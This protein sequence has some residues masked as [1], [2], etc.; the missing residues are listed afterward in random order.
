MLLRFDMIFQSG[1]RNLSIFKL[2]VICYIFKFSNK[3]MPF[4]QLNEPNNEIKVFYKL[5]QNI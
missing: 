3:I 4:D 5:Y 2:I 1:F